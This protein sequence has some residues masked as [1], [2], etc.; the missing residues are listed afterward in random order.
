MRSIRLPCLEVVA[1]EGTAGDEERFD[2]R[3]RLKIDT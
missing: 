2:L 1:I 3:V